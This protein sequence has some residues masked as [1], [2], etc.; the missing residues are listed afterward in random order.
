LAALVT[1]TLFTLLVL[2][3]LYLTVMKNRPN[4]AVRFAKEYWVMLLALGGGLFRCQRGP[5]SDS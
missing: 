4:D 3:T 5:C 2:P 1:S